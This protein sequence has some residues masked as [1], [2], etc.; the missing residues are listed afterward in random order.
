MQ[1]D[2][3]VYHLDGVVEQAKPCDPDRLLLDPIHEKNQDKGD[4]VLAGKN[5]SLPDH[6]GTDIRMYLHDQMPSL[7]VLS[8]FSKV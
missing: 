6:S 3:M 5:R 8:V 1:K 7:Y 2:E 4:V